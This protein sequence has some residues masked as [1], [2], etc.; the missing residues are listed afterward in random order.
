VEQT[1]ENAKARAVIARSSLFP[2]VFF[3]YTDTWEYLSKNG[4]YRA[5][6]PSLPLNANLVDL[7]L[8]FTYEFDFWGKY[9]NLF[10]AAVGLEKAQE[11]ETAQVKLITT[12]AVAQGFFALKTNL[13]RLGLYRKLYE[14]RKKIYELQVQLLQ[15]ALYSKLPVLLSEE[16][17]FQSEQLIY[18]LQE[19]VATDKH[20]INILVGN[21]P[22]V[23]LGIDAELP[24]LPKSLAIPKDLSLNLIAR[25]PDLMAQIWRVESIAHEVGAA[26]AN[27]FPNISLTGF[28]GYETVNYSKL[29]D[30]SSKTAGI[31]PALQL[32]VYTA[33]A[34]QAGIDA[35]R[36]L[37][38]EAVF[39]YNNLILK[40]T[41]EVADVL[42]FALSVFEQ[43]AKQEAIVKN[44]KERYELTILRQRSGLD[45]SLE[46]F[47]FQ[48]AVIL[49]EIENI[50]LVFNQYVAAV[51]LIKALGGGYNP[52]LIPIRK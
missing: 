28:L 19:E 42:V 40:S 49:K 25:R 52:E 46:S 16:N 48:E 15:N 29:F 14:V 30:W 9:R 27:F 51:K 45:N 7:S 2:L 33:G 10:R 13:V 26:R 32:P 47:A 50:N 37:F 43:Q 1:I 8:S 44:S 21:G 11:A 23:D 18:N 36:A 22:D 6:N 39:D 12:T 34:I 4:L 31:E 3:N 24:P 5:F 17:L 20:L 41:Q 35:K 38:D